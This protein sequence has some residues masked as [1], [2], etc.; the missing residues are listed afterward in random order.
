MEPSGWLVLHTGSWPQSPGHE[1][2]PQSLVVVWNSFFS[3]LKGGER[4]GDWVP[5][6]SGGGMQAVPARRAGRGRE[7]SW[8]FP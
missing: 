2:R 6:G 5:L 4:S 8:S 7:E 1:A 3:L